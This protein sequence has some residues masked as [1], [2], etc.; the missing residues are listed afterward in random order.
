MSRKQQ[1][2]V[3]AVTLVALV[4]CSCAQ[5]EDCNAITNDQAKLA[6]EEGVVAFGFE[7]EASSS[8]VV[9]ANIRVFF[10]VG[11]LLALGRW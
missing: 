3:F 9:R 8:G 10:L 7:S 11:C 2:L 4:S 5:L 6:C 1:W